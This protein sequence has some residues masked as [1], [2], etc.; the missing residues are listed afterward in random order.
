MCTKCSPSPK[1]N[2]YISNGTRSIISHIW[3]TRL[4]NCRLFHSTRTVFELA[5]IWDHRFERSIPPFCHGH[6]ATTTFCNESCAFLDILHQM[7]CC[8]ARTLCNVAGLLRDIRCDNFIE[9]AL[10]ASTPPMTAT[11]RYD[12]TGGAVD[13][14]KPLEG[15]EFS[16]TPLSQIPAIHY[17]IMLS[18]ATVL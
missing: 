7:T 14:L 18:F 9:D 6:F 3:F 2:I 1:I 16:P 11:F 12:K 10:S 5:A 15:E 4:V 8:N 13:I 17:D